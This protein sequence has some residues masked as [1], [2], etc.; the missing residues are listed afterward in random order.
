[1]PSVKHIHVKK[2]QFFYGAGE[3]IDVYGIN[4]SVKFLSRRFSG[5]DSDSRHANNNVSVITLYRNV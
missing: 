3:W 1:V 4:K 2:A 5:S